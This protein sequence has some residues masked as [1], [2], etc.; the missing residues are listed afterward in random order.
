M[1]DRCYHHYQK[2]CF[3]FKNSQEK[4]I[5]R[6]NWRYRKFKVQV[7]LMSNSAAFLPKSHFFESLYHCES[8]KASAP[9]T[10]RWTVSGFSEHNKQSWLLRIATEKYLDFFCLRKD[11]NHYWIDYLDSLWDCSNCY[12]WIRYLPNYMYLLL[13][14]YTFSVRKKIN[15]FRSKCVKN[16]YHYSC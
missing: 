1:W 7:W 13:Y 6:R 8:L 12:C 11:E 14:L 9:R 15:N 3:F 4:F 5:W 2:I 16:L 10:F